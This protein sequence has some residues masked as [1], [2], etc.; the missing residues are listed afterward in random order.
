M[1]YKLS[2]HRIYCIWHFYIVYTRHFF[3]NQ[4][5]ITT[6]DLGQAIVMQKNKNLLYILD[7]SSI[8]LK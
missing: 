8:E 1:H 4:P 5:L 6:L 7:F 3:R 2:H